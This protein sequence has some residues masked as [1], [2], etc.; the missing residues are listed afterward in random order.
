MNLILKA[1][2]FVWLAFCAG[3][4]PAQ[5]VKVQADVE[6]VIAPIQATTL[7]DA[8]AALAIAVANN[9][10]D[11]VQCFTDIVNYL[12]NPINPLP[13][14]NG[15]LSG[16]EAARTFKGIAIPEN[17]HRSCSVIILDAPTT[18]LKLGLPIR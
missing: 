4:T 14:V 1:V 3:C 17:I 12:G 9:D 6:M 18:A 7:A 13:V 16:L 15:I 2:L 8:Q 10:T 5:Q 11:G